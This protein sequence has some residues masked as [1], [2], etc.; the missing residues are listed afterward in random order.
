[1]SRIHKALRKV[2]RERELRGMQ[3]PADQPANR[4]TLAVEPAPNGSWDRFTKD[5]WSPQPSM[6]FFTPQPTQGSEEFRGLRSK[7][8]QIREQRPLRTILITS[9]LPNEGKSF[10]T[11][12]LAQAIA[13]QEGRKV[14]LIDADLRNGR[15][16]EFLGAPRGPGLSEYLLNESD[17]TG[18]IKRGPM[19][20]LALITLGRHVANPAELLANGRLK[21]LLTQTE[22][23][24]DWIV[25]DSPP[26][27][28]VTDPTILADYCDGVLMVV[29]ADSTPSD[30]A[31]RAQNAFSEKQLI[32][33]V[34][35]GM[36]TASIPYYGAYN[37]NS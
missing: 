12:N 5:Q 15:L 36:P 25:I 24:F 4:P 14:L 22:S 9:P 23:V 37:H 32:G 30:A 16:H 17:E 21:N 19:D 35:N 13:C 3:K 28:P 2:E 1:M 31:R 7:L 26:V 33:S 10:V 6:L 8:Y 20:N 18:I 27:I 34:L 29:R 11:A